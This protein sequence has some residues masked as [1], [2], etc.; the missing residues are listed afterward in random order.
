MA[1]KPNRKRSSTREDWRP[2]RKVTAG[3]D[4]VQ[5]HGPAWSHRAIDWTF[6]AGLFLAVALTY[7]PAWNGGWLFDDDIQV[8]WPQLYSWHGLYRIWF[9][10]LATPQYYP[11]SFSAFW[12]EHK[13]W[14]DA[15]LGFHLVNIFLHA[16]AALILA[17]ILRRLMVPGA[18]L[19]AAIFAL[20]PVCVE[21]VAWITELKNTLSA[22]FYLGAILL[23]LYFDQTRNVWW[24]L[25]A[26][27]LFTLALLSKTATVMLPAVLPVI[28]W[29]QRGRLSWKSDLL[30]LAPFFLA[31]AVAGMITVWVERKTGAVGSEFDLAL[32]ERCLLPGRVIWFYLGKLFWPTHLVFFYPRWNVSRTVWWQYLF[33]AAALLL[34]A[35]LWRLRGQGRAPLAG[36]LCFAATLFPVLGFFNVY[37]FRYSFVADHF[38]YLASLGII[39]LFA[40]GVALLLKR[41]EGW[42]KVIG[43]MGCMALVVVLAVLSWRQS[44]MYTDA[45]TLYGTTVDRNPDC[46]VAQN[47]L[48]EILARRGQRDEAI[49]HFRKALEVKPDYVEAHDNLGLAL[50]HCGQSDEAIAHFRKALEIDPGY[51]LVHN[52][53]A[54]ALLYSGQPDEAMVHFRRALEINPELAETHST[55]GA[56]LVDRGRGDEAIVHYRKAL[57]IKPDYVEVHCNL[58]KALAG[59][60][61]LEEAI[62]CYRKALDLASARNDKALADFIRAEIMRHQPI[63]PDSKP[64]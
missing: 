10:V 21:S 58:A 11:M 38:Q 25:I 42:K 54:L 18:Y 33:P 14:G 64:P 43:Q 5:P 28:F 62:A 24:Y 2:A 36:L 49:A 13:L 50:T 40:A 46:P 20:H 52:N 15:T 61:R 44:R 17:R 41:A 35:I 57:E 26:F 12:V 56:M 7:Q 31:S 39:T 32:V 30:P 23:Y 53:L 55:L 8:I 47:N 48:G 4:D 63:V 59:R 60:G 6:A 27:V 37:F 29:W 34:L 3:G 51:A 22:V 19:A 16:T 1:R 9:D 45:E